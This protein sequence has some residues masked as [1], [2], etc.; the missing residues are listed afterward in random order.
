M[1]LARYAG[2]RLAVGL[3]QV[4]GVL[5]VV[6]TIA[7]AL[8]G[9]AAVVIA[10][11]DADP[12]RI[13]QLRELLGLDRPLPVQFGHWLTGL[14][15]GDLGNS[16]VSGRPVADMLGVALAPTLTLAALAFVVLVPLA[17]LLGV[18]AAVRR[19][20][21]VDRTITA[22]AVALYAA[23]EFAMAIVL[24]AVF[25]VWLG[26]FAP[27]AV[28][29]GG[30]LLLQPQL[31]VLP[32]L[33]LVIRPVCS[34]SRLVRAS[35]I[36]TLDSEYIRHTLRLGI[37][38]RRVIWRHALPG[39]LT[40]ATQHLARVTDWLL[41]GVVVVEAVFALGGLGQVLVAAVSS[42]DLPLLMGLVALF[43]VVT[44][45]VNTVADIV[46]YQL[47]PVAGVAA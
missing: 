18:A 11:D 12:K 17:L 30:S 7:A 21:P 43:A 8:P 19:D 5:V 32:V 9:D 20:R 45:T 4:L 31:W 13:A 47:N 16:A 34:L 10:G 36:S 37:P 28:G 6:F 1:I 29:A 33:L 22:L 3:A 15:H 2:T 24:V 25:A 42:R 44:V 46:A 40:P 35:M 38:M 27:T 39:S 26:W 41:G 14:L 23:P